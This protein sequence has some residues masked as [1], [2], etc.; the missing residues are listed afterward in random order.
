[1]RT[2]AERLLLV[3]LFLGIFL[4]STQLQAK[5]QAS[6][7]KTSGVIEETAIV[8]PDLADI[9]PLASKLSG[10]L[11]HLESRVTALLN[12]LALESGYAKIEA[13]L[14]LHVDQFKRLKESKDYRIETLLEIRRAIEKE[15]V[16]L[17]KISKPL[18]EKI[19]QAAAW[20]EEWLAEKERWNKWRSTIL[21]DAAFDQLKPT[22]AEA[23]EKIDT[24]LA[25]VLQ[26]L[27][28]MLTVQ[29]R[30]RHIQSTIYSHIAQLE[31]LISAEQRTAMIGTFPPMLSS[32]Y[33]SQFGGGL[34]SA[35]REGLVEIEWGKH[36]LARNG[37]VILFQAF[38]SLFVF[39]A[40]FR[41]RQSLKDSKRWP[42][43]AERPFSAALFLGV[44][45]SIFLYDYE[46]SFS[47][48][49]IILGS[50]AVFSFAR[51]IGGLSEKSE[52]GQFVYGRIE[53]LPPQ[54]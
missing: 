13:K 28:V 17:N 15:N 29:E 23:E 37:W 20:R 42:L 22:F 31:V 21:K 24:A 48:W 43:L 33:Y 30:A 11:E 34:W 41:N 49:R 50:I 10:R 12:L 39:I 47:A 45:A 53:Q 1:M 54:K 40:L 36:Y 4:I 14:K 19:S 7:E 26:Q 46:G 51:L 25:L 32:R 5:E 2:F 8:V 44:M 3:V 27:K 9:M 16:S 38:I 35:V 6:G 52:R 18:S